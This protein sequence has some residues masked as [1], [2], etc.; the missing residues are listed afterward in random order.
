MEPELAAVFQN[1][2]QITV[3]V[4]EHYHNGTSVPQIPMQLA[5]EYAHSC[6]L[7]LKSRPLGTLGECFRL[8]MMAFLATTI[9]MPGSAFPYYCRSLAA[10]F[11]CARIAA[12]SS[13]AAL[14]EAIN[15]WFTVVFS[16]MSPATTDRAG[17]CAD[18]MVE[19]SRRELSWDEIRRQLKSVMWL[20]PFHDAMGK[21]AFAILE[22]SSSQPRPWSSGPIFEAADGC[23]RQSEAALDN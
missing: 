7:G 23:Y 6:L 8:G 20:D 13:T 10:D 17:E 15:T 16:M 4:N 18:W 5:L 22:R 1:L 12:G 2:Q 3:V 21:R 9:C 19:L 11:H 14:P